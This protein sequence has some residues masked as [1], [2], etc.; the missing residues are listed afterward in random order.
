M[1][2][3]KIFVTII[4]FILVFFISSNCFAGTFID[5]NYDYLY[6]YKINSEEENVKKLEE[7]IKKDDRV[8][9]GEFYYFAGY[10]YGDRIYNAYL[11]RKNSFDTQITMHFLNWGEANWEGFQFKISKENLKSK[12]DFMYF[13]GRNG[14]ELLKDDTSYYAFNFFGYFDKSN[15]TYTFPLVTNYDK[16]IIIKLHNNETRFFFQSQMMTAITQVAEIPQTIMKMIRKTIPAGLVV[17][18]IFLAIYLIRL[19][20]LRRV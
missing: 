17:L 10:N 7:Q 9:S 12:G 8:I 6:E 1:R 20:I 14:F 16:D 15:K 2:Y 18:S 13:T 19:V 11:I 3:K 4:L 5:R